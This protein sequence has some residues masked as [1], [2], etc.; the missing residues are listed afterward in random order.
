MRKQSVMVA[1][2]IATCMRLCM[3]SLTTCNSF[4]QSVFMFGDFYSSTSSTGAP[5]RLN[6]G[7]RYSCN[8]FS[9]SSRSQMAT[10]C[11]VLPFH[12]GSWIF[13]LFIHH[14]LVA[15]SDSRAQSAPNGSLTPQLNCFEYG[16]WCLVFLYSSLFHLLWHIHRPQ[17]LQCPLQGQVITQS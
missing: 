9:A 14:W 1:N 15:T 11:T 8:Y 2:L 4:G 13:L 7:S 6:T 17:Y 5:S 10:S 16:Y 3:V 12:R